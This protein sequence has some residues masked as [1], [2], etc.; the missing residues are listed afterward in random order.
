MNVSQAEQSKLKTVTCSAA[1]QWTSGYHQ[2]NFNGLHVVPHILQTV[3][4]HKNS[5]KNCNVIHSF[6]FSRN[7]TETTI[8]CFDSQE[9][10]QPITTKYFHFLTSFGFWCYSKRFGQRLHLVA[11]LA[12]FRTGANIYWRTLIG[13]YPANGLPTCIQWQGIN[14]EVKSKT[15]KSEYLTHTCHDSWEAVA[16]LFC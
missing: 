4:K 2:R 13:L 5:A 7:S 9:N 12:F 3:N 11:D 10:E 8:I 16:L 6:I 1:I 14:Y 15:Q